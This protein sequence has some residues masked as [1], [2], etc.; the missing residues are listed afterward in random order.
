MDEVN[1]IWAT[2]AHDLYC[3][4]TRDPLPIKEA[5]TDKLSV[6][7]DQPMPLL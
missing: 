4:F 1:S 7:A 5:R 3:S 6:H 2:K